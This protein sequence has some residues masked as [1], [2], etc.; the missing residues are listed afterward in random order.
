M[1][2]SEIKNLLKGLDHESLEDLRTAVH[3][4]Q[5]ERRERIDIN[6]IKPGMP[7]EQRQKVRAEISRLLQERE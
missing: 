1:T 4:E 6:S 5:G 7:D 2:K 3:A